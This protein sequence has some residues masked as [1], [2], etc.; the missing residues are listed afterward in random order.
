MVV[1]ADND[2]KGGDAKDIVAK[3]YDKHNK[4]WHGYRTVCS[5]SI[6]MAHKPF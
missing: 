4:I 5:F 2:V 6:I 3:V 1:I